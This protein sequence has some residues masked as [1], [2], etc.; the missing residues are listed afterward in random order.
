[1]KLLVTGAAGQLGSYLVDHYARRGEVVGVDLHKP[2]YPRVADV[3]VEG[4]IK[5]QQLMLHLLK[6]VD[7]V[8]HCAAFIS[9]EESIR[10]PD[11]Y[12]ENNVLG[13][14]KLLGASLESGVKRFVYVSSAAVYGNPVKLPID[15]AHP[16]TPISPYGWS[17][18][19]GEWYAMHFHEHLDLPATIVR[20]FNI[21]SARQDP[22]NPYTGV[23]S[24]FIQSAKAGKSLV[25]HGDGKQT[26][27]FVSAADVVHFIE[28]AA[29]KK[30]AVGQVFN[31]GTGAHT[32]VNK[33]AETVA[34]LSGK[35]V[36]IEHGASRDGDIKHSYPSIEKARRL[37]GYE[38]RTTLESGLKEL[39]REA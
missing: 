18:L 28:L 16:L 25:V 7:V 13:T 27:D 9:V 38:P 2:R 26:R 10:H 33:L 29:S 19:G 24:K 34:K 30:G 17:K 31:C 35:D 14:S 15:E 6:D 32:T 36:R 21:Y 12:T 20:P 39:M 8:V 5:N 22:R 1:M 3:T 37:L 4:D 11:R 23:I